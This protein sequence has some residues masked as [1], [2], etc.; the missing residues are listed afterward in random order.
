M[1]SL[2]LTLILF[3]H[4]L[5]QVNLVPNYSFEDTDSCLYFQ[6]LITLARPWFQ[7]NYCDL[8]TTDTIMG[9]TNL[10]SADAC[11]DFFNVK[12][13]YNALGY[14]YPHFGINYAGIAVYVKI[15]TIP[16][17]E[18]IEVPVRIIKKKDIVFL[19]IAVQRI[20]MIHHSI[21]QNVIHLI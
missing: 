8:Y 9:S 21:T 4:N 2:F 14:Q 10:F 18:Y 17:C 1:A 13:P 3:I 19:R 16:S 6:D 20:I 15:F 11:Y 5:G 7:P 12:T